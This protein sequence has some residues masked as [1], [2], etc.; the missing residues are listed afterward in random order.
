MLIDPGNGSEAVFLDFREQA[1]AAAFQD[2][3]VGQLHLAQ[4]TGLASGV[5]GELRG[6]ETAHQM[7]G[8]LPWR[9]IFQP[10]IS[11]WPGATLVGTARGAGR[12]QHPP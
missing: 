4:T 9:Q 10:S 5:P 3:Y 7:Y 11:E 12:F 1:P 6:M 8:K 2:M